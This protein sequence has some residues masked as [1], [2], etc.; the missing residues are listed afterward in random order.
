MFSDSICFSS[1]KRS[2]LIAAHKEPPA[3]GFK[4]K[5]EMQVS[6]LFG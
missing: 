6:L 4:E 2:K 1:A 3:I 5:L